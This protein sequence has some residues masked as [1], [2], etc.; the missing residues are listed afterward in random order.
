MTRA[1]LVALAL[2][3]LL[4]CCACGRERRRLV[5][6][7][8]SRQLVIQPATG[9][10]FERP[11]PSTIRVVGKPGRFHPY[12]ANAWAIS[13]GETLF[14]SF[15]CAGCHSSS[16][17]GGMGPALLDDA[18]RYGSK[19]EDL[20]ETITQGRPKGMPAFGRYL[21]EEQ[22]WELVAYVRTL[23]GLARAD[24]Q[25]GREDHMQNAEGKEK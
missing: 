20:F 25:S 17:G 5:T 19:P 14:H 1:S 24:A 7:A 13:Q 22:A 9:S 8:D 2:L 21:N 3:A 11:D 6:P 18:W 4:A 10:I 23:P 15:N 12:E 16:G